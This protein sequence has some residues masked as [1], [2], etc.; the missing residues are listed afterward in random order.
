[1]NKLCVLIIGVRR[2]C[3]KA[4]LALGYDVI[5][6]S[7]EPLSERRKKKLKDWIEAPYEENAKELSQEVIDK[8]GQ[9][10]IHRV[11]ANTEETVILGARVRQHL[12]LKRLAVDVTDRFHNKWVMKNFARKFG[13]P[14]TN[15]ALI[16]EETTAEQLEKE[17]GYPLVVKPVDSS[18]ARDVQVARNLDQLKAAMQPGL[19]AEAFV[20]GSEVSVETFVQNGKPIFNNITEYLHQWRKSVVPASLSSELTSQ[21]IEMN[22][23]IVRSFGVDRGMTHAEFYITD[24]GPVFGEIAIRPPGGYYMNLI[25]KTYGFD[26]WKAYVQLSCGKDPGEMPHQANGCSA[27]YMLHPGEGKIKS[28]EGLDEVQSEVSG[29][30]DVKIR[31]DIGDQVEAHSNTSNEVG[32]FLFSAPNRSV[33]NQNLNFIENNFKI[34]ME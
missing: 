30:F 9:Y 22:N 24:R 26:A 34:L 28:I 27:V 10:K 7:D 17:L 12:K 19:L 5:L 23:E 6:W 33:L 18:G 21:I 25:T 3:Y 2:P 32:H 13:F 11:I 29:L 14:V 8:L 15:Y 16:D 31:K 4:A 1:M 20:Q